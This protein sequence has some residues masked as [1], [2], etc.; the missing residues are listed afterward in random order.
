MEIFLRIKTLFFHLQ[1]ILLFSFPSSS[2]QCVPNSLE[3]FGFLTAD[4]PGAN[5]AFGRRWQ[6][7]VFVTVHK[8][9][10]PGRSYNGEPRVGDSFRHVAG[11]G[12][13]PLG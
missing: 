7:L 3:P 6:H 2:C 1:F 4:L 8:V 9:C 11:L 13:G 10:C 5:L 12:V